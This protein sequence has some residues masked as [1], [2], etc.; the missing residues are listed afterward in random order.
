MATIETPTGSSSYNY[1]LA[2]TPLRSNL[3]L[4]MLLQLNFYV[5]LIWSCSFLLRIVIWLDELWN[6]KGLTVIVAYALA[7][8]AESFRLYAGFSINLRTGA[9]TMWLLLTLTPC[10]L[11]PTWVYLR[12][13]AVSRNV[14]LGILSNL[15]FVLIALE[16]LVALINHALCTSRKERRQLELTGY[17]LQKGFRDRT[18]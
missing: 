11:L 5:S 14:W 10:V 9:T 12:L 6:Y 4:Q 3:L 7:V 1:S 15:Q 18:K 2:L 16:A 17:Q 13:T 8:G